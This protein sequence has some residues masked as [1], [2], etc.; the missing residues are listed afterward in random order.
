MNDI[1]DAEVVPGTPVDNMLALI[2]DSEKD[3]YQAMS[4]MDTLDWARLKPNQTALLLMQKPMNVSGGG[5]M[6]LTF[7]QALLFAVRAFE[8]GL[9]PFSDSVWFDANRSAVNLTLAGKKELAR[10]KG[11]DIGPP[12]FEEVAREWK[13]VPRIT[14]AGK[15]AQKLG[16]IKDVGVIC[17]L[18]VGDPKNAEYSVYTAWLNEWLVPRSSVWLNKPIHML[19]TRAH[20]KSITMILGT[21]ASAMP[22]DRDI[23]NG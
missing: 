10:L 8:L 16:F 1:K 18:R 4:G 5:T 21:G 15:E 17:K 23:D 19:C 9:S 3:V 20:E 11:I 14:D 22:D 13:E 2:K 7:K 6:Y 12:L